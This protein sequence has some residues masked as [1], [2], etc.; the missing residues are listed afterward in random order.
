MYPRLNLLNLQPRDLEKLDDYI[1]EQAALNN[2]YELGV[3]E[4]INWQLKMEL[5]GLGIEPDPPSRVARSPYKRLQ[6]H[7]TRKYHKLFRSNT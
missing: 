7:L 1:S 3:A 6:T 4:G 5:F 2:A